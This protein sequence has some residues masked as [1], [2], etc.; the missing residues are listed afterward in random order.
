MMRRIDNHLSHEER[1]RLNLY[2]DAR[3]TGVD[4]S[5]FLEQL[6]L[7][8]QERIWERLSDEAGRPLTFRAFIDAPYPV[9]IGASVELVRRIVA[10]PHR[11][12][13]LPEHAAAIQALRCDV[14]RLLLEPLAPPGRPRKRVNNDANTNIPAP[15]RAGGSREYLLRRLRRDAPE[16][17]ERVLAGELSAHA[18]AI[19]A[20]IRKRVMP[21][22]AA[23]RT[24]RRLTL[25][26]R[27]VF[28]SIV[29]AE[30]QPR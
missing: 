20:G 17:A 23:L 5:A 6:A 16:L 9:G 8:V 4:P 25:E 22:A 15:A 27:E 29:A 11:R 21:L 12:E 13:A 26:E 19:E 3:A 7:A 10:L 2:S 18:A 28:L 1:V 24:W 14:E 30:T